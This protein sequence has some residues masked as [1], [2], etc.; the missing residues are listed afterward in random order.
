[1]I[2]IKVRD[3]QVFLGGLFNNRIRHL[4][5]LGELSRYKHVWTSVEQSSAKSDK[6]GNTL[7]F[8]VLLYSTSRICTWEEINYR[9]INYVKHVKIFGL[10]IIFAFALR[11][12]TLK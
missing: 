9:K 7:F 11:K 8:K 10:N 6:R 5:S 12:I 1:M 2:E 3:F 4:Y